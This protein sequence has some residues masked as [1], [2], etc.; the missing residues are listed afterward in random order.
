[1]KKLLRDAAFFAELTELFL[2]EGCS[3]LSVA[4]IAARLRCSRRRL[5]EFAE[6]KEQLFN[7]VAERFFDAMLAEGDEQIR[8]HPNPMEALTAFFDVGLHGGAKMSA[9]FL[10]DVEAS[11]QARAL[12]DRLQDTR[13]A[14][15][16][17]LVD[18]GVQQGLFAPFHGQFVYEFIRGATQRL[19]QPGVLERTGLTLEEV[20]KELYRVL[21]S[22]LLADGAAEARRHWQ[23][24]RENGAD[25]TNGVDGTL[26]N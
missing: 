12:F 15:I 8:I 9:P 3:E 7:L 23:L 13:A 26:P 21:F 14:G 5:Y 11:A 25:H 16:G 17:R 6:T 20:A 22:G 19:R 10:R 24:P 4:A 2:Q 18:I 1:M